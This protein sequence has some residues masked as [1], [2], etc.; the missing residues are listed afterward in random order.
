MRLSFTLTLLFFFL[1][2]TPGCSRGG[3]EGWP[4]TFR[5]DVRNVPYPSPEG[6][7][8]TW[9]KIAL[10]P[11]WTLEIT[12]QGFAALS[13]DPYFLTGEVNMDASPED[14][15]RKFSTTILSQRDVDRIVAAIRL[16]RPPEAV[17]KAPK[18]H[19]YPMRGASYAWISCIKT[20]ADGPNITIAGWITD[21]QLLKETFDRVAD[22]VKHPTPQFTDWLDTQHPFIVLTD[23]Q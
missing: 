1:V 10:A 8:D 3:P 12:D 2:I 15:F 18:D 21:M 14:P 4:R 19:V 13:F 6:R 5:A 17:K 11:A 22:G 20:S 9:T 23:Q 7:G 16:N